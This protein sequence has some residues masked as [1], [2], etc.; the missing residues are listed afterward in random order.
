[1]LLPPPP[2]CRER[3]TVFSKNV[4]SG[5]RETISCR[6]CLP[7]VATLSEWLHTTT[8]AQGTVAC[9]M[10]NCINVN[11][12]ICISTWDL[13]KTTHQQNDR[14]THKHARLRLL[15]S[16]WREPSSSVSF[17]LHLSPL[18]FVISA[19]SVSPA[20][21]RVTGRVWKVIKGSESEGG[22]MSSLAELKVALMHPS[23]WFP[24]WSYKHA[25][26]HKHTQRTHASD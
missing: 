16:V 11:R 22:D 4:T 24:L 23:A 9:Y 25:L 1:M 5:A 15:F 8:L 14:Q 20:V 17:A 10:G 2:P 18:P 3:R 21:V 19:E 26:L 12:N 7:A 6:D 13:F